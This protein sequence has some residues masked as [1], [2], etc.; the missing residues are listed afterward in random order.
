MKKIIFVWC[1]AS[2]M[3]AGSQTATAT[4]YKYSHSIDCSGYKHEKSSVYQYITESSSGVYWCNADG[5]YLSAFQST[6]YVYGGYYSMNG[7]WNGEANVY[8]EYW[9]YTE[10]YIYYIGYMPMTGMRSAQSIS[11][12]VWVWQGNQV[13]VRSQ[14]GGSLQSNAGK[15]VYFKYEKPLQYTPAI[16]ETPNSS[17]ET[18]AECY[19]KGVKYYGEKNYTQAVVWFRK[20]AEKGLKEAQYNL[21]VC[22]ASGTGVTKDYTQAVSWFRKA[23]EQGYAEAQCNLGLRYA[24]GEGVTKDQTQAMSW[25]RKAAEQGY[26]VAQFNLGISYEYG[27]GVTKDLTQAVSWYRKAAEKG[28]ANA[29]YNLATCYAFGRG[30]TK[31]GNTA[32]YW[33]EE[34]AKN[35]KDLDLSEEQLMDIFS[36][37][38]MLKDEG[39]SS[40]RAN[41]NNNSSSNNS[42]AE[43]KTI[44]G[45]I[46]SVWTEHNA[47]ENS[48]KGM[49]IHV[50]F[51]VYNM[52]NKQGGVN[53]WFYFSNGNEV[54]DSK[55]GSYRT[56][57]GH[58]S[59]GKQ[60]SPTYENSL[61]KD[62]ELFMPYDEIPSGSGKHDL[63]FKIGIFEG[64]NHLV[65]SSFYNFQ[66][67]R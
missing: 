26:A 15:D 54:K 3:M 60:F 20:A 29:Q 52:L 59:V 66:L 24:N 35:T 18:A 37:E 28:Y 38:F 31:D 55:S 9:N 47:V 44:S 48:K 34:H 4:V 58:A 21:G 62:F 22:Y 2:L 10:S 46:D 8:T 27:K 16:Y 57:T 6:G 32:L 12:D 42:S 1:A 49:K 30:V 67:S 13:S 64:T 50:K 53:A 19:N 23:A 65:S 61:Y 39:Y 41:L 36:L 43:K 7:R 17:T 14:C 56:S 11:R 51:T 5:S 63:K 40:S 33:L 45:K 25:F